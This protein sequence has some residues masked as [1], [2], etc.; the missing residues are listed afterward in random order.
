MAAPPETIWTIVVAA[1]SGQ[2]FGGLKQ[3]SEM[4]SRRMV[5]RAV[6]TA[7]RASAGVVVVVPVGQA[8]DPAFEV[9]NG[10]TTVVAGGSTR[11]ESVRRGLAAVP[12]G[13][14]VVCVHDAVRP[15]ASVEL[16]EL[17]IAAVSREGVDA[18]VPGLAVA[19]TVKVVD[20]AGRVVSTPDRALLRAVQTPQAFRAAALRAA[21]ASSPEAT[22]DAAVVEA[23]GGYVVV[24]EGE[25]DNRKITAAEDLAWAQERWNR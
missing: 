22:D 13:V 21:H 11:S 5:D 24:V 8:N 7:A 16:F 6:E 14:E 19:D 9:P 25:A 4:G 10:A 15:F 17:V 2:R 18:A 12:D 23:G 20:R 3:F 1:G